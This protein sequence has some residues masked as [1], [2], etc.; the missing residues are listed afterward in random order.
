MCPCRTVR[1][2][3]R[4]VGVSPGPGRQ[5]ARRGEPGNVADLG[6]QDQRGERA[7]AGQ[8]GQDLDPRVGPGVL[9]DL[10]VEPAGD[11]FQG[12]DERQG[13]ADHLRRDGGQVQRGEPFAARPAPAAGW[14]VV[15][16]VSQ[17]RVDPV[18][19]QRPQ[20]HQLRPVPQ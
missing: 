17:D 10:Q 16:V 3:P 2:L 14:P 20:P 12:V 8:L 18:L 7:G 5:L 9:A 13:V 1:S 4:T 6:Q 15:A 11:R 19:Q